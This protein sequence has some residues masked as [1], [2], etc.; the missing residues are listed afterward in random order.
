MTVYLGQSIQKI[1]RNGSSIDPAMGRQY[2]CFLFAVWLAVSSACQTRDPVVVDQMI[3]IGDGSQEAYRLQ[4][5]LYRL[6]LRASGDGAGVEWVGGGCERLR[7]IKEFSGLCEM[8]TDGQ[9]VISN[10]TLLAMGSPTAV[11]V[12]LTKLR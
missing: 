9:L 8:T 2:R 7:E 3:N 1:G 11:S 4:S 10:P 5:G 6:E 12:R